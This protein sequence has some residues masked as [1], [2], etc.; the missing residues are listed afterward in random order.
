MLHFSLLTYRSAAAAFFAI[1]LLLVAACGKKDD[2]TLVPVSGKVLVGKSPLTR[3]TIT[4]WPDAAKGNNVNKTPS[5][6]I[7][8][9]GTYK[10]TTGTTQGVKDGAPPGWYLV[11]ISKGNAVAT[12]DKKKTREPVFDPAFENHQKTT[13]K[14]EVKEGAPPGSYDLKVDDLANPSIRKR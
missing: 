2:F 9:D 7:Q 13:L 10:L 14:M 5:A 8:E 12:K 6:T 1:G 11:T 3:G 4:F